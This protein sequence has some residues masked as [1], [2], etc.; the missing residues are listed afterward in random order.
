MAIDYIIDYDC[1]PKQT[2]T[3]QTIVERLKGK[4]R[5]ESIIA[6]YRQSGDNRPA[7]EMGFEYSRSTPDGEEARSVM[8]VQALLDAAEELKPLEPHCAG[9]P[10]N[11]AG[12]PFGCISFI[13]YPISL[14]AETWLIDRLPVPDDTLIWLLLR[15]GVREFEYDG[16]SVRPLREADSTYFE[17]P[18]TISRRLGEL[19]V[20]SNQV[21]EMAFS[22]GHINP[23]HAA[24]LLLFFHAIPRDLEADQIMHITPAPPNV[25][26][27]HPF[28]IENDADDDTT[29]R[30]IKDFLRALYCA[31]ALNVRL[32]VDA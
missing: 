30:E 25:T 27:Q 23:N 13:Q 21:F 28:I 12:R 26:E 29:I 9:C 18:S 1:I 15:Q 3:T 10:A 7:S 4:E 32:L 5:A 8:V 11:R 31:W 16:E 6:L 22:V 17:A 24:L 14:Q 2:L 19:D 20:D